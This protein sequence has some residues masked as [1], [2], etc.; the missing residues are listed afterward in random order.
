MNLRRYGRGR[1]P[2]T[3]EHTLTWFWIHLLPPCLIHSSGYHIYIY[4][5]NLWLTLIRF[6]LGAWR[7]HSI[8]FYFLYNFYLCASCSINLLSLQPPGNIAFSA[9]KKK[10]AKDGNE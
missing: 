1:A 6:G 10:V 3:Y 4:S 9:Y 7:G 2:F 5:I 8:L